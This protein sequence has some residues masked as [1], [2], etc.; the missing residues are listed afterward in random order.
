MPLKSVSGKN[1]KELN[2]E[3]EFDSED[4]FLNKDFFESSIY[5]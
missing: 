2:S 5:W 1:P 4:E 3:S